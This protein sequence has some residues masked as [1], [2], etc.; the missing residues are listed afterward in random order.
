MDITDRMGVDAILVTNATNRRYLTEFTADDHAPD[1][2]SGVVIA[3]DTA[4]LLFT[5]P[6]NLPWAVSEVSEGVEVFPATRPWTTGVAEAILAR[7]FS[8]VGFE[9]G[10][11]TVRD[12]A[13]L[14]RAFESSIEL[15][16]IGDGVD[17][18]RTIKRADEL[19]SIESALR[20]T[21]LAF[22][23]MSAQI[24][25]SMTEREIAELVRAELRNAGSDGEA[26]PTI[27]ASGPN[28]AKP[29]HVPGD[30]KPCEGEPIVVDMGAKVDGFCGDLTRT[31]WIGQPGDQLVSIYS[32]V[33]G[34]QKRAIS[35]VRSGVAA[36]LVDRAA[37]DVCDAAGMGQ[38]VIHGVGHG[39]GLRIHEAPA[40]SLASE[41]TLQTG[42]VITIEPG[43]YVAGWGGVR[44]E[45]VLLVEDAGSR[46]LTGAAKRMP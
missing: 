36:N 44:I 26:F 24:D 41:A 7:G 40:V 43:L 9:D 13:D 31:L 29:H 14:V 27:V 28:A 38:Y 3:T 5:S 18:L 21:D 17:R 22:E 42:N 32:V 11:M 2:S 39:L 16:P 33:A 45:D 35:A 15:V 10:S 12:H 23:R 25:G 37:R 46:N 30:R 20:I 4:L 34:A 8:R 1:E 6:T 19:K